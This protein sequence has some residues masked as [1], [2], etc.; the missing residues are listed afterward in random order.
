MVAVM[1][2]MTD[3]HRCKNV[4]HNIIIYKKCKM[5]FEDSYELYFAKTIWLSY[6]LQFYGLALIETNTC[7]TNYEM[8]LGYIERSNFID[9]EIF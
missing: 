3:M 8:N 5:V 6:R 2:Y 4:K 1:V 9:C 7:Y